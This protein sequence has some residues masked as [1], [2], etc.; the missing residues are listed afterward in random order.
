M[1]AESG[2]DTFRDSGGLWENHRIEDVAT[3]EAFRLNPKKVLNFYNMRFH[4]LQTVEPN[5]AHLAIAQI[6]KEGD[7]QI[8]VITQ[9]VDD[10]HERSGSTS[11][12]HLHGELSKCRSSGNEEYVTE[13]P[14]D[15]I[16][17]GDLCP[18]G[19]QLRPHIVWFGEM[20]PSMDEAIEI[21][22]ECDILVVVGTSLNVYPAAGLAQM[23][24]S[25]A[26]VFLIDPGTFEYLDPKIKQI[27]KP[28]T[29]GFKELI[30]I[31]LNS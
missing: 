25:D 14:P 31:L 30:S 17:L 26:R 13:M 20:V 8:E 1:S 12:L 2:I 27:K 23:A 5:E 22:T 15:G 19:F 11:V 21:V 10:L 3:P 18:S 7:Y 29:A 4:Q 6:E 9:N 16:K 28:A 24:P